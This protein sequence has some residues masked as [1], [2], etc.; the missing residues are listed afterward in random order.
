M[1]VLQLL[2]QPLGLLCDALDVLLEVVVGGLEGPVLAR[3]GV[4]LAGGGSARCPIM[5][6]RVLLAVAHW[7]LLEAGANV[8]VIIRSSK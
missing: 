6:W 8:T 4:A 5:R 1:P 3:G 7:G 2:C